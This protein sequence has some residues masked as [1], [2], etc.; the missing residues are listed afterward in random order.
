[1]ASPRV[2][3]M[4]KAA[5]VASSAPAPVAAPAPVLEEPVVA[6]AP[7]LE[8]PVLEEPALEE[9]AKPAKSEKRS[10][11]NEKKRK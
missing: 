3:K 10:F 2:R 6:P 4:R 7:V 11:K 5:R 9:P 8:E 1:M